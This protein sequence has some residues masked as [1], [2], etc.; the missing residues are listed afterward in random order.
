MSG[1]TSKRLVVVTPRGLS[2]PALMCP[3]VWKTGFRSPDDEPMTLRTSEAPESC[4]SASSR[5]RASCAVPIF[6]LADELGRRT[7]FDVVRRFT[8]LR[9]RA[10]ACLLLDLERRRIAI[11]RLR[12]TPAFKV[13]LHQGF[14]SGE[15]GFNDLQKS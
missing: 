9:L 1:N 10:L 8:V 5:S 3:M 7:S 6:G 14:A 13:R 15:M 2:L 11:P 12:T 4:S